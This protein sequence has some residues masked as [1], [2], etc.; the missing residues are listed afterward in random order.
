MVAPP[1]FLANPE[2]H[3]YAVS[4]GVDPRAVVGGR[5]DGSVGGV[6]RFG[7]AGPHVLV[8]GFAR[9][10]AAPEHVVADEIASDAHAIAGRGPAIGVS[11]LVDVAVDD[12]ELAVDG[13]ER[14]E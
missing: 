11:A 4:G 8:V 3:D 9:D 5:E 13:R 7:P 10:A 12:V 1:G 2:R 14:G 6:D